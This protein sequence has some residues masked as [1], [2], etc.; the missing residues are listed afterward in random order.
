MR[1]G[2]KKPSNTAL[3]VIILY[4]NKCRKTKM[5]IVEHLKC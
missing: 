1:G 2:T 4:Y 5:L 3:I